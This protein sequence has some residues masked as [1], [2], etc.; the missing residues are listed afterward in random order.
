MH[1]LST[2]SS[3]EAVAY[4]SQQPLTRIRK[5]IARR[6]KESQNTA[7]FLTTFNEVNLW[8]GR[9]ITYVLACACVSVGSACRLIYSL[10]LDKTD[11][12]DQPYRH[13]RRVRE[14][15]FWG[16]VIAIVLRVARVEILLFKA[17]NPSQRSH[18]DE[19]FESHG[20]KLGFMSP[21]LMVSQPARGHA[22]L[23]VGPNSCVPATAHRLA[24][25]L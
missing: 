1:A 7:A 4:F 20:V 16:D 5:A 11:R 13:E 2:S 8:A 3:G 25:K 10:S 6:L 24:P 9:L 23:P 15:V 19:F 21:F 12:Y 18:K 22:L 17:L 14:R